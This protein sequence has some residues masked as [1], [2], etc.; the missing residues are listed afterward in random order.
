L[1]KNQTAAMHIDACL[2]GDVTR[3]VSRIKFTL[4]I[5][6]HRSL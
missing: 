2:S 3:S 6:I 4:D 5:I 1:I